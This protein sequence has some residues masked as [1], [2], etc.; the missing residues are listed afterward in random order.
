M[1]RYVQFQRYALVEQ[2]GLRVA[3]VGDGQPVKVIACDYETPDLWGAA[4]FW[5]RLNGMR[6]DRRVIEV[7]A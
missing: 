7:D 4:T 6:V 1:S 3:E 2:P 5:A